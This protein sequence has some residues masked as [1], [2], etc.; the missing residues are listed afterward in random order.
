MPKISEKTKRRNIA[1][2]AHYS[3]YRSIVNYLVGPKWNRGK[4][5]IGNIKS[6]ANALG[7]I[8]IST[9]FAGCDVTIYFYVTK[10]HIYVTYKT[11][12]GDMLYKTD[13][14]Y[15]DFDEDCSNIP[16]DIDAYVLRTKTFFQEFLRNCACS[17]D[18]TDDYTGYK[19]GSYE[20]CIDNIPEKFPVP[21][22]L[23][24]SMM[25]HYNGN[26]VSTIDNMI[27]I[28]KSK[29]FKRYRGDNK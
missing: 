5:Q 3:I 9:G 20:D 6:K 15:S 27:K 4:Y 16:D 21:F 8:N 7:I 22:G 29:A 26:D 18:F 13:Y 2:F 24:E 1:K 14:M 12:Y 11:G 28:F 10:I 19:I 23:F 17:K 25:Y